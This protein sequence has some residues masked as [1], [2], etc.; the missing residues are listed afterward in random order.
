MSFS[1]SSYKTFGMKKLFLYLLTSLTVLCF[2]IAPQ[3][4]KA[5]HAAGAEIIYQWISDSTYRFYFKFYR[6]C[7]GIATPDSVNLCAY[8]TCSNTGF[9][10]WMQKWGSLIGPGPYPKDTNGSS[11]ATGCS[12]YP[13]RCQDPS[14]ILPGFHEWWYACILTLPQKCNSWTFSAYAQSR[15]VTLVNIPAVDLYVETTF[16]N[17]IPGADSNSSP[18]FSIKPIPYVCLNAPYSFNNGAVDPNGD[19]LVTDII[20]P[21]QPASLTCTSPSGMPIGFNG[22]S[23]PYNL[24]NNPLQ[25]NL[26]FNINNA[27]GQMNFTPGAL[28]AYALA[29]RVREYRNGKLLGHII[30]DVQVQ[31]LTC[32]APPPQL[33]P[34]PSANIIGGV[35]MDDKVNGCVNQPLNFCFDVTCP[36]TDE[37]FIVGDNHTSSVPN[38]TVTYSNQGEDS[39]RGCFSWTPGPNDAGDKT[40]IVTIKDSTCRP[41][42]VMLF[43]TKIIPI[44]IWGP[45]KGLGDTSICPG[46]PAY[47]S[48]KGGGDYVWSIIPGTPGSLSCLNCLSPVAKP[49]ISTQY[50]VTSKKDSFCVNI[51]KDTVNVNVLPAATF[52]G[53]NDTVTCPHNMVNLDIH[54][55]PP[56]G[57]TYKYKWTPTTY[58]SNSTTYNPSSTP[59][60]DIRYIVEITSS[61]SICKSY[62]TINIDVLDGFKILNPDTAICEGT[63]VIIRAVGDPR[64]TYSWSSP[65]PDAG[66][67]SP[68]ILDPVITPG[69][70]GKY[71]YTLTASFLTCTDSVSSLNI[72]TQPIPSVTVDEDTKICFGDTMKLHGI[73]TPSTYPFMLKWT[74]GATLDDPNIASPVFNATQQGDNTLTFTA[75]SSAGC[76]DSD[77]VN[78]FV[79]PSDFMTL[80]NDTAICP[81]DSLQLTMTGNGVKSF[82]WYPDVNISN[83]KGLQPYVWPVSTQVYSVYGIDTNLCRDTQSVRVTVKPGATLE[84]PDSVKLYPG[85]AYQMDPQSNCLY[86]SW[87]P[88]VG[89][90]STNIS[91]PLAQPRVNTKYYVN[92][93]T[94]YGC[95]TTDSITVLV[96]PDSYIDVPNAFSPG[97]LNGT[98]KPLHLGSAQLKKFAIFN[99][100]GVKVFETNDINKGWDGRYNGELQ[101]MGVYIYTLD[102][103]LPSGKTIHKNGD[104]TLVR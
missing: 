47:L 35:W 54:P 34:P 9:T 50:I 58:L 19:S 44:K 4:A 90:S 57:V 104:I 82:Y 100:W 41:P 37:I 85:E 49:Y 43:Y 96:M 76:A 28:G 59:N 40:F 89:L 45:T 23:P 3:K 78:L 5:S 69:V 7:T 99:R 75:S 33:N 42:G 86:Y 11:V 14:S 17:T 53:Q 94:E 52:G 79:F 38:A 74:P 31:V 97:G 64:Y 55:N 103:T 71:K 60:S 6:D 29:T 61:N 22:A 77:K 30:R 101:P 51:N 81:K 66:I 95:K 88:N 24:I 1:V 36:D 56:A 91:N 26:T 84:L 83:T 98:L 21:L 62:D 39:V 63:S 10:V 16:D 46:G 12:L 93:T 20:Q 32:T 18:Y 27:T 48:A 72:E 70:L 2:A 15:N 80:S 67:S 68:I 102:A 73:V 8:N 92:G 65:S 87:F 13:N 25:T